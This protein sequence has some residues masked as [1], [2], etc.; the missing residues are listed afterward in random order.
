MRG[1]G[2]GKSLADIA[3]DLGVSY[4]TIAT[5]CAVLKTKLGARTTQ[6]LVRAAVEK[7]GA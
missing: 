4:K 6:D 1:L 3:A 5:N 7:R 2:A